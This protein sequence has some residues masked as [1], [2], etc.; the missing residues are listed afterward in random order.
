MEFCEI[1]SVTSLIHTL[2]SPL[3]EEQI[4]CV[5]KSVLQG[6]DYL[7]VQQNIYHRDLKTDNILLTEEGSVKIADFGVSYRVDASKR[8][9]A[10]TYIGTPHWLSPEIWKGE[11][12]NHKADIWALG[13]SAYTMAIGEPP[14]PDTPPFDVYTQLEKEGVPTLPKPEN[15][16]ENFKTFLKRCLDVSPDNRPTAKELLNHPFILETKPNEQ[17]LLPIIKDYL[18]QQAGKR[19][20]VVDGQKSR[21]L[22]EYTRQSENELSFKAVI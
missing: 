6:L 16:S 9:K 13:I 19:K 21:A 5:C 20:P 18:K 3:N 14:F 10:K 11:S 8:S 4:K 1:G 17:V 15:Y 2:D 7:H 22:F 12:Y